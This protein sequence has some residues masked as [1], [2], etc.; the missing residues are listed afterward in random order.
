[1]NH[2]KYTGYRTW[3]GKLWKE[4]FKKRKRNGLDQEFIAKLFE[5]IIFD[6]ELEFSMGQEVY[7]KS[8]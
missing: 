1:M 4:G 2:F 7:P 5:P 6:R 8:P 3:I